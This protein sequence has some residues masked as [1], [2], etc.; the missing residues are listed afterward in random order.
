MSAFNL[1]DLRKLRTSNLDSIAN[2]LKKT[3]FEKEDDSSFFKLEKDKA[4]NGSAVLRF[5]PKHPDDD[6]PFV[7]IYSHAFQNP[8]NKR[9]YIENSRTTINEAD[10]VAELNSKLWSTGLESDKEVARRQRRK[11]TYIANVLVVHNPANPALEGQVMQFKF[12]KKIFEKLADATKKSE[13]PDDPPPFDPFD[14][15]GGANFKLRQRE[16]EGYPNYDKSEFAGVSP[17]S[18]DEDKLLEVLNKIQPLKPLVD[19]SK[20]KSYDDLKKKLDSVLNANQA[21]AAPSAQEV[22]ENVSSKPTAAKPAGKVA[23]APAPKSKAADI[24]DTDDIEDYFK[25]LAS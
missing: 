19:A 2:A 13:F 23:E 25:N 17:I 21:G 16:V 9:W 14:P 8:T 7:S 1:A 10:P 18:E 6:L 12:G 11:L 22:I 15:F 4:G 24:E 20:F 5:L 3:T